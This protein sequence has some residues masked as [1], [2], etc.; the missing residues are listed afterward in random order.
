MSSECLFFCTST[1]IKMKKLY[2]CSYL[3]RYLHKDELLEIAYLVGL[4]HVNEQWT[5]SQLCSEIG[6]RVNFNESKI[7]GMINLIY[8]GMWR[9]IPKYLNDEKL[10]TQY[11]LKRDDFLQYVRDGDIDKVKVLIEDGV[12][13]NTRGNFGTTPLMFASL[14]GHED[15]VKLLLDKGADVDAKEYY[16]ENALLYASEK[17][18]E[19]I[20]RILIDAGADI[21]VDTFN[22]PLTNA[23]LKGYENIVRILIEAGADV[24]HTDNYG[25]FSPLIFAA[26]YGHKNIVRMLIDAGADVDYSPHCDGYEENALYLAAAEGHENIVEML[27]DAGADVNILFSGYSPLTI[28]AKNEHENIVKMLIDAGADVARWM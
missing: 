21:D 4:D 20:I 28:A 7:T 9:D 13:V 15:I 25:G 26:E 11:I 8:N 1:Q 5:K 22:T 27:I 17:G 6:E 2:L 24:N 10:V 19:N 23:S 16:G 14:R 12:N 3:N 18:H